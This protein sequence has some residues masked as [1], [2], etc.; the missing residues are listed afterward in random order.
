MRYIQA[1]GQ[2][3]FCNIS[4]DFCYV[5]EEDLF[6]E[7]TRN[8]VEHLILNIE[9]RFKDFRSNLSE[10]NQRLLP[11]HIEVALELDGDTGKYYMVDLD[12]RMLFWMDK[13]TSDEEVLPPH[14]GVEIREHFRAS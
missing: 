8:N 14:F 5:T 11:T 12:R 3:Y 7:D 9:A 4:R 6:N 2:P 1:E 10:E 13:W